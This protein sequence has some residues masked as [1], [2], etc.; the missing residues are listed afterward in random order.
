M[1]ITKIEAVFLNDLIAKTLSSRG[2]QYPNPAVGAMVIRN[3]V[4]IAE[5]YHELAGKDHAEVIALNNAKGN[6]QGATLLITLEPCCHHGKTKPC[7]EQIIDAGISRCIWA[8][9]DPNP[10][11]HQKSKALLE[12]NNVDVIDHALPDL[13]LACIKEFYTYYS[14]KRPYV[15]V[16][17]ALS[18]DGYIA[19]NSKQLNYISSPASL[20]LVQELRSAVQAICVGAKTINIDQPRLSV[21]IERPVDTQPLIVILDPKNYVDMAWVQSALAKGR[22]ILLFQSGPTTVF[23]DGFYHFS[24]LSNDKLQNWR[25]VFETLYQFQ[26]HSVLVEGGSAVFQSLLRAG[27]YDELWIT[28][29]PQFFGKS[30]VPFL[31]DQ[32]SIPIDLSL[33]QVNAYD[34]DVVMRFKN[35]HVTQF[36]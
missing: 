13:G 1:K 36:K 33:Y 22:R 19:P 8:I 10:E 27:C 32:L 20:N 23:D 5:G 3:D 2:S 6:T 7:V 17:A 21:R 4:I 35:N 25:Y 16:K 30:G 29:V 31:K 28:K 11:V 12:A 26:I 24:G 34:H 18:F 9:N 15:Y 14:L